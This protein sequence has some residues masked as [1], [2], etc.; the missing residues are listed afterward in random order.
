MNFRTILLSLV[1]LSVQTIVVSQLPNNEKTNLSSQ[2]E[3]WIKKASITKNAGWVQQF[4]KK[5]K[6]LNSKS[7]K[8]TKQELS[9]LSLSKN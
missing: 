6:L 7:Q 4:R 3:A 2:E 5:L 9:R 1:F 8:N